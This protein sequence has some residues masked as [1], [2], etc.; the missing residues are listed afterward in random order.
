MIAVVACGNPNRSDDGAGLAVL[1]LLKTRRLGQDPDVRLLDA[2]T[3]GM[4]AMFAARGCRTLIIIDACRSG[5][6]PG[7]IF[8]V[9]GSELTQRYEPGLNLHDFRWD[10]ALFAG[11]SIFREAFPDDIVVFLIEAKQ[12]DLGLSLSDAVSGAVSKATDRIEGIVQIR[13]S[14][15]SRG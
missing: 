1:Q 14:C 3:D 12:F 9:P 2:G 11:K 4:A 7:A 8:E 15:M 13:L 10:H 6:A 5:S